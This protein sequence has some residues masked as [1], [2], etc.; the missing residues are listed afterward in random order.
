MNTDRFQLHEDAFDVLDLR[1]KFRFKT[2]SSIGF[3]FATGRFHGTIVG[4]IQV[5]HPCPAH[6]KTQIFI[7]LPKRYQEFQLLEQICRASFRE[8]NIPEDETYELCSNIS[9]GGMAL[10]QP[11]NR[12]GITDRIY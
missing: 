3:A 9:E 10:A 12:E 5:H 11:T 2:S 4:A 7:Q 6:I 1:A 8:L